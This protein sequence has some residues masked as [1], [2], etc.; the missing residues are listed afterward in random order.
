MQFLADE[1]YV[2]VIG[3]SLFYDG[4]RYFNYSCS[5]IEFIF[6]GTKA[7]ALLWTDAFRHDHNRVAWLAVFVDDE[8]IPVRRF[9]VDSEGIYT[10]YES[11]IIKET[12]LRVVKYSE[13]DCAKIGVKMLQIDGD[14]PPRPSQRQN[15]RLEFIGD[16]ITCGY[17][18]EGS[19]MEEAFTTASQNPWQA[20]AAITARA[21]K[22]EYHIIAW[23][24][25]G[26]LSNY[27]EEDVPNTSW[28][29]PDL[30]PYTDKATDIALGKQIEK[31]EYKQYKPDC[32]IINL[33]TNDA[34]YTKHIKERVRSF[35]DAYYRFVKE[36]RKQN[37][38]ATIL[39]TL[40][41]MGQ[42]LC[43]EI[44]TQVDT[45]TCEG[46]QDIYFMKFDVQSERDGIGIHTH[47]SLITHQKMAIKLEQKL[48]ELMN[49]EE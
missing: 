22:A 18:N 19:F 35:G 27:T 2:S 49:W 44:K 13:A 5:A 37:P 39:C 33:G 24:G 20:Y 48:R 28:L 7:E 10:L 12:K 16:S 32:I 14:Q 9:A 3:R 46:E 15:R 34:S 6:T 45:L 25:I 21:L 8:E 17:G 42:D 1:N 29:M 23:S 11:D 41:A 38:L 43:E 4:V 26:V 47:P 31:W 40:G 36:I 30:Y